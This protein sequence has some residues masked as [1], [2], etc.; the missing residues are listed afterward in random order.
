MHQSRERGLRVLT[1]VDARRSEKH[2]GVLDVLHAE[3]PQRF[4]VLGQDPDRTGFLAVE[5]LPIE[6]GEGLHSAIIEGQC[7]RRQPGY[8]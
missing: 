6:I 3:P 2:D 7:G 1:A 8:A 4:Q 5:E